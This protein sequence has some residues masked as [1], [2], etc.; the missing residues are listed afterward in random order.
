MK[1]NFDE[2]ENDRMINDPINYKWAIFYFNAKDSRILVPK[3]NKWM[4]WTFNFANI[5]SYL[6]ILG[7]IA[8][9]LITILL[10]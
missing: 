7:I 2:F 9:I 10:G 8:V 3:Y 4:G 5:Y 1:T 6:I